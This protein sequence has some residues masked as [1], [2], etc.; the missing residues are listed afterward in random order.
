MIFIQRSIY[1]ATTEAEVM[2]KR[3]L[4]L[5]PFQSRQQQ[6]S[7]SCVFLQKRMRGILA[8]RK[9]RIER[10]KEMAFLGIMHIKDE[11]KDD[12][13]EKLRETE[14]KRKMTQKLNYALY[15]EAMISMKEELDDLTGT[16][17]M[18]EMIKDRRQWIRRYQSEHNNKLPDD[19]KLY[20]DQFKKE[21]KVE[22]VKEPVQ[23]KKDGAAKKT[24]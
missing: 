24:A 14:E 11:N 13:F 17:K 8:R 4:G 16:T 3:K 12:P 23:K 1:Q 18:E 5:I 9:V 21:E 15:E 10:H 7:E 6:E 22:V 19:I 2:Q 20:H